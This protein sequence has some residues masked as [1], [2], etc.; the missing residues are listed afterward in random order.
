MID[1]IRISV[2]PELVRLIRSG[3]VDETSRVS[4]EARRGWVINGRP[5]AE[6]SAGSVVHEHFDI[7]VG[8]FVPPRPPEQPRPVEPQPARIGQARVLTV[9]QVCDLLQISPSTLLRLRRNPDFPKPLEVGGRG[10]RWASDG[11]DAWVAR[12]KA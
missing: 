6:F 1:E 10:I 7:D 2:P 9:E 11:I 4:L 5:L 3:A 8:E 12:P